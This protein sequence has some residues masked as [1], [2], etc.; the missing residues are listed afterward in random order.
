MG[1][2]LEHACNYWRTVFVNTSEGKF[3]KRDFEEWFRA[4]AGDDPLPVSH[5][6]VPDR[7]GSSEHFDML[8]RTSLLQMLEACE[9]GRFSSKW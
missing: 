1:V 6:G 5:I 3:T 9:G 7:L 4:K 2:D 8:M